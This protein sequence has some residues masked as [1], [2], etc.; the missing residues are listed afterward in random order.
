MLKKATLALLLVTASV[1]ADDLVDH[2]AVANMTMEQVA[3]NIPQIKLP[4]MAIQMPEDMKKTM[5][6][7]AVALTVY[8]ALR[9]IMPYLKGYEEYKTAK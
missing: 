3:Q 1:H 4:D 6:D 5:Y 7:V 8:N 2:N 9:S